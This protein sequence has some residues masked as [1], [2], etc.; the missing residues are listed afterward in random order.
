MSDKQEE[1]EKAVTLA[2][3]WHPSENGPSYTETRTAV[4]AM[5]SRALSQH[6]DATGVERDPHGEAEQWGMSYALDLFGWRI[7]GIETWE[8]G[9][10]SESV[11]GDVLAEFNNI[12]RAAGWVNADGDPVFGTPSP[13]T[14]EPSER[15]SDIIRRLVD[16]VISVCEPENADEKATAYT[17]QT[18]TEKFN[19][20]L[21][22]LPT[23]Q[24]DPV[25]AEREACAKVLDDRAIELKDKQDEHFAQNKSACV[26]S[27]LHACIHPCG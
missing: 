2:M 16:E 26:L 24:P 20:I 13:A 21:P 17:R 27:P 12:A 8:G 4:V 19:A 6:G 22:A 1:I 10:G 14:A 23:P 11:D 5:L 18:L 3:S 15:K 9:D 7:A 25:A